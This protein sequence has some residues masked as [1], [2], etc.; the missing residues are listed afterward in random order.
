V[1]DG[2]EAAGVAALLEGLEDG[3]FIPVL[4]AVV[5]RRDGARCHAVDGAVR[6]RGGRPA[7]WVPSLVAEVRA[8]DVLAAVDGLT[9]AQR[10][11]PLRGQCPG[12]IGAAV[13]PALRA[14][15]GVRIVP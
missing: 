4:G 3:L 12:G 9:S 1:L 10:L 11:V 14:T 13:V 2:G 6:V 5:D 15:A 7:G 8:F